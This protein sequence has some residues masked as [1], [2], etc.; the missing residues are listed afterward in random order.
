MTGP[1]VVQVLI[2]RICDP[3]AQGWAFLPH[4]LSLAHPS[5]L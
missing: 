4:L 1:E 2:P 5:P 3:Q